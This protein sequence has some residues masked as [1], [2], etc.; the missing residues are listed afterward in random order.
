MKVR[1]LYG[2]GKE[3]KMYDIKNVDH[4]T[5]I[6]S[7]EYGFR[8]DIIHIISKNENKEIQHDKIDLMRVNAIYILND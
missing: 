7:Y 3:Q 5:H 6:A 4:I 1:V 8:E 2:H